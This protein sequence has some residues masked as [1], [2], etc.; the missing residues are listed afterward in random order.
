MESYLDFIFILSYLHVGIILWIHPK[1]MASNCQCN[2]V[3]VKKIYSKVLLLLALT[4]SLPSWTWKGTLTLLLH[5]EGHL[6]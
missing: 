6:V 3:L 1:S 2:Y 4:I 5:P